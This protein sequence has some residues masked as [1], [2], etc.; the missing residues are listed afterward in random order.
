MAQVQV[1]AQA[2]AQARGLPIRID[3]RKGLRS[4]QPFANSKCGDRTFDYKVKPAAMALQRALQEMEVKENLIGATRASYECITFQIPDAVLELARA[5]IGRAAKH[6][7]ADK[8]AFVT[9]NINTVTYLY[10]Q[11][12]P[13]FLNQVRPK[14]RRNKEWK[15]ELGC[16]RRGL[17]YMDP[18]QTKKK[19]KKKKKKRKIIRASARPSA[20]RI[21]DGLRTLIMVVMRLVLERA[22]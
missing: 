20:E 19:K 7:Q 11:R 6:L 8:Q 1:Q 9:K 3:Q 5:C 4:K 14:R 15:P 17:Q 21:G 13:D 10:P 16:L 18:A 2:Q 12:P 22:D